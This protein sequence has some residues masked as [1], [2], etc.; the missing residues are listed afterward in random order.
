MIAQQANSQSKNPDNIQLDVHMYRWPLV[1][2]HQIKIKDKAGKRG[3]L[4]QLI[5][6]SLPNLIAKLMSV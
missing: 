4:Q 2:T 6:M 5:K 3:C 1:M